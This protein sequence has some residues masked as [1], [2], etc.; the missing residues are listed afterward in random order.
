MTDVMERRKT[1]DRRQPTMRPVIM[2]SGHYTCPYC[3]FK[4]DE[5]AMIDHAMDCGHI[6]RM[7]DE[8][9]PNG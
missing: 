1:P 7:D 9:C 4:G 6:A 5:Q 2:P 3:P 8:G